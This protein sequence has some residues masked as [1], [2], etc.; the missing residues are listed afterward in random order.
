LP[1]VGPHHFFALPALFPF[2]FVAY[3][4]PTIVAG[5]RRHRHLVGV[6]LVNFFLGWTVVGWIAAL[7]W[8]VA[9]GRR[10]YGY[11]PPNGGPPKVPAAGWY[12]D[13]TGR[14]RYWSGQAW[15]EHVQ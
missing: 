12:T 2:S 8:S 7:A 9:G 14:M 6:V 11:G 10:H 15:T 3:F 1:F 5:V 13:P 4:I